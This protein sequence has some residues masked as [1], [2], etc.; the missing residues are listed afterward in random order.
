MTRRR[1]VCDAV[2][3][4]GLLPQTYGSDGADA[5]A[6]LAVMLGLFDRDDPRSERIVDTT[7]EALQ[8]GPFLY[9]YEPGR[10]GGFHGI[11]GAFV[12]ASWWAVSALAVLGRVDQAE[13]KA[14][15]IC[16]ALPGLL[17]EEIDPETGDSR[18]NVPL[19]WSH[20]EAARALYLLEVASI[21]KRWGPL[22][23]GV[24]RV[25]R[26]F[27]LWW[28]RRRPGVVSPA[29]TAGTRRAAG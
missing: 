22:G 10:Q 12:P 6:L 16:A 28:R 4:D 11:E 24:W 25:S 18:G 27:R 29:R 7:I 5:S 21:R 23:C 13:Q 14:N 17:A 1:S 20:M 15:Q 8:S 26:Y 9:R 19:V 2:R 3:D